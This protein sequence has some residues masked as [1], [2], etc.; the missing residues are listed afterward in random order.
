M[1]ERQKVIC[2][3]ERERLGGPKEGSLP[4]HG[5]LFDVDG[6]LYHKGRL[7]LRM[8]LELLEYIVLH[9]KDGTQRMQLLKIFRSNR[10]NLRTSQKTEEPLGQ[11]QYEKIAIEMK[12]P[13]AFVQEVVREWILKRPLKYLRS[14]LRPG[15][16]SFLKACKDHGILVGALSDYPVEDKIEALG[17]MQWFDLFL[18]STDANI[19]S[20]KPSPKG[21]WV[22]CEKWG[23]S[24]KEILYIGDRPDVDVSTARA[25][26]CQFVMMG[27]R[28]NCPYPAFRDFKEMVDRFEEYKPF[29]P[30]SIL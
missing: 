11:L 15:T 10:E 14:C 24:P 21:V 30:V 20:F 12:L 23:L 1:I 5:I 27:K 18:C 28:K 4:V 7:R 3:E 2:S 17:L 6:T 8:V 25:A 22:A 16:E 13:T 9:P 19:N 26:G 29:H